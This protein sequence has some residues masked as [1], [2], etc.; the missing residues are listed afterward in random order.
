MKWGTNVQGQSEKAEIIK[1]RSAV[2]YRVLLLGI[3]YYLALLKKD[4]RI[5]PNLG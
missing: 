5:Y 4:Y 1:S 2:L 3:S